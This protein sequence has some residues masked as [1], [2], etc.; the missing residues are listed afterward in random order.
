[1]EKFET[2][3]EAGPG[4]KSYRFKRLSD[5]AGYDVMVLGSPVEAVSLWPVMKSF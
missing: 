5:T 1:M 3:G 2:E 4:V